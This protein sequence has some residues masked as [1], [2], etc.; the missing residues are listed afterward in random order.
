M[1]LHAL[2]CSN[3]VSDPDPDFFLLVLKEASFSKRSSQCVVCAYSKKE[4]EGVILWAT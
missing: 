2:T 1:Q 4:I 3:P